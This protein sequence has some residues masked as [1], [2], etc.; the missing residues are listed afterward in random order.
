[1]DARIPIRTD[2]VEVF[3]GVWR[4]YVQERIIKFRGRDCNGKWRFGGI[5]PYESGATILELAEFDVATQINVDVK[6]I[7]QFTGLIDCDG[8][9][10]F[11]GDIVL[12]CHLWSFPDSHEYYSKKVAKYKVDHETKSVSWS[13]FG[14]GPKAFRI[15]GNIHE[16]KGE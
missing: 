3:G 7:G 2:E 10:I 6:T 12:C 4:C 16:N 11:E 9:E 14:C 1:M 5:I 15:I 8:K 13:I